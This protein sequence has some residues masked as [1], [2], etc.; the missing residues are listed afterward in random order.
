VPKAE[1][2]SLAGLAPSVLLPSALFH[3]GRGAAAPV[4]ALLAVQL[5]GN[6]AIGASVVALLGVGR[7]LADVPA[8]RLALRFGDRRA[9]CVS[10]CFAAAALALCAV[11]WHW[12]IVAACVLAVGVA[13]A[14]FALAWQAHLAQAAPEGMRARAMSTLAG[15]AQFGLLAGPF[16]SSAAIWLGGIRAAFW[17]AAGASALAGLAVALFGRPEGGAVLEEAP[18]SALALARRRLRLLAT[19]GTAVFLL[20]AV[21]A[22]RRT[23]LPLW[24]DQ[25]GLDPSVV[26]LVFGVSGVV[27]ALLV[28]PGGRIMDAHGRKLVAVPSVVVL[29]ASLA[30]LPF[31]E[32]LASL[33]L[34]AIAVGLGSGLGA[35][36]VTTVGVDVAPPGARTQFL[37]VW[38]LVNDSGIAVG[39]TVISA[40]AALGLL[41]AGLWALAAA[42][43]ASAALFLVFLPRRPGSSHSRGRARR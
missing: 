39:P 21:R 6:A 33:T 30:A 18:V 34:V 32:D 13:D 17:L 37:G 25:L 7:I 23:A 5:D 38:R 16:L 1:G 28:Y 4:V 42:G 41:A 9:M 43:A 8:G 20:G 15:M 11:A 2:F 31:A 10:A 12:L 14:V 19:L 3:T 36:V 40:G 26:S 22:V 27:D 35:G 24:G 29:A